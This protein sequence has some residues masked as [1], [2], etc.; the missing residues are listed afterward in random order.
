MIF[1]G[2]AKHVAVQDIDR[3]E[4]TDVS[5]ISG[6]IRLVGLDR[7]Q[8]AD[9]SRHQDVCIRDQEGLSVLAVGS[10]FLRQR[11]WTG[12]EP[13]VGETPV[14]T[15]QSGRR[16]LA[17]GYQNEGVASYDSDNCNNMRGKPDGQ[18]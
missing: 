7:S 13:H 11:E 15:A 16:G 1:L 8:A 9:D 3:N 5:L 2:A 4:E 17:S 12:L 6:Q 10:D 18:E 14:T